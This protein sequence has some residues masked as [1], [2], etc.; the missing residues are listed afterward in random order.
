LDHVFYS[1]GNANEIAWIIQTNDLIIEQ[2]RE[3][4]EIYKN[5]ISNLQSKYVALH[6]GMFW[7]IGVFKIKNEDFVKIKLDDKI[8]FD[9]LNSDLKTE[10]GFI[11]NRIK[12]IKQLTTQRKLKVQFELIK[13]KDNLANKILK[14]K[15]LKTKNG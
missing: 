7:G 14:A 4:V 12:F 9:Q 8:M 2:D 3:H 6:T 11:V 5:R 1:D 15:E 10:D 13:Q